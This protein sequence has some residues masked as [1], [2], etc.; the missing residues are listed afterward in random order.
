MHFPFFA[1]AYETFPSF[2]VHFI[3]AGG[4]AVRLGLKYPEL[5][6]AVGSFSGALD[7]ARD[8]A[9][10]SMSAQEVYPED[11]IY[12]WAT[13]HQNALKEKMGI[14]LTVGGSEWLYDDHPPFIAHLKELGIT[15]NYSV[16]GDL[17]HNLGTSKKLFGSQMI[18]FLGDHY[19]KPILSDSSVDSSPVKLR[20]VIKGDWWRV[21]SNPD[22][23]E[24]TSDGQEPVDFG[25]WQAAD[26]SWQLWSCIRKTKYPGRTRVFHRWEGEQ[27]TDSNWEPK[28][29]TFKGDG[30][31]G[32]TVGG[33]QAPYVIKV[34][35]EYRMYYGDYRHICLAISKDGKTFEKQLLAHEMSG[36]FGE[37][38]TAMARDPMLLK[39]GDTWYCYY[40]AHPQGQHG[41]WVR[42]SNDLVN[43]ENPRLV[44][45]GGQTGEEWWNFECPHVVYHEG[46][47]Y[48]FHTQN[49]GVGKQQTSVFRSEEPTYFGINDDS[50]FV[51]HLPV[52][53]PEI[54]FHDG[55]M[56][57]AA[58][59]E[60]LDGIRIAKLDWEIET[61]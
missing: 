12:Y 61:Q 29:I 35:E 9:G 47:Y 31:I 11:N 2:S 42:T 5:F 58:L 6:C 36:L 45:T 22:L 32:E 21:A 14:Y 3:L 16:Q 41:I 38:P 1:H 17:G 30:T 23:V 13:E 50:N 8:S 40:S 44:M 60:H 28:G 18:R 10:E 53:A 52:A 7:W 55:N 37:G 46:Y 49:Y 19:E 48:L 39:M 34:D 51:C 59:S 4:G 27:L 15:V 56:Y 33:M 54:I 43:F 57:L 25:I 24:W 26:G 20:P